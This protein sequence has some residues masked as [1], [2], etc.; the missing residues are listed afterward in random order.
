[1]DKYIEEARKGDFAHYQQPFFRLSEKDTEETLRNR[2]REFNE[3]GY[4]S[5]V[6]EY[7][8]NNGGL[9][10]TTYFDADWWERLQYVV[11]ICR[12]LGMTFWMQDA[13]PFPT[14]SANGWFEQEE[15]KHKS[16]KFIKE[17]HLD[18]VGPVS[19]TYIAINDVARSIRGNLKEALQH[20]GSMPEQVL[21]VVAARR[22]S[23]GAGY[24]SSSLIDL[25][26]K[27]KDGILRADFP[28]G[29]WRVFVIVQSYS[30][31]RMHFMNLLDA[32]SV[33][34]QIDAV[35]QPHY[36]F[37]KDEVGKTWRG[38][39]YDEPE[40]GNLGGYVFDNLP[41]K[42]HNAI[43]L[44]LPWCDE[45]PSV[46]E[47][48]IG[49]QHTQYLPML[50]YPF[51]QK[52]SIVRHAYMDAV[53]Q[54]I[55]RNYNGQ[56]Y[57]WCEERGITYIGHALED[58]NSHTRL[59]CGPGHFFRMQEGQHI[60]G[61]DLVGGQIW[62]GMDFKGMSWYGS[63]D[64]DG[65]FYHYGL[66][67]LASSA[68]HI[69]PKKQGKSLCENIGLYGAIAGTK[70]RKFIVDHLLVNGINHFI[71]AEDGLDLNVKYSN[72]LN[73]YVDRMC[74]IVQG[75]TH[76]AP[77]AVLYHAD[78]EW[79]G[80]FQ[81]FHEPGKVLATNQIDYDVIPKDVFVDRAY[82]GTAIERNQ[83]LINNE[84]YRAL[85]IPYAER[86]AKDV[87]AFIIE[88]IAEEF[89]VLFVN[90]YPEGY[91]ESE[92]PLPEKLFDCKV[93]PLD[94][95]ASYLREIGIYDISLS[96]PQHYLRYMH[97]ERD[98]VDLYM[99]HNE[100][101][102]NG[103]ETVVSIPN[104]K[105][106]VRYDVMDNRF[107]KADAAIFTDHSEIHLQLRQFEAQIYIFSNEPVEA[108]LALAA[109]KEPVEAPW[110]LSFLSLDSSPAPASI[111]LTALID[112]AQVEQYA[113][114]YGNMIYEG[115]IHINNR[116]PAFLSLGALYECVEV[117][118][119][120]KHVG[121]AI[122]EPYIFYIE[123]YLIEGSN[124]LKVIVTNNKVRS[125][126]HM[127][128]KDPMWGTL[129]A[130][131][132][133]SFEAFGLIGPVELIYLQGEKGEG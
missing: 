31:G 51:D 39:F 103:I 4:Y 96:N 54:L 81:Y 128:G 115:T 41:G 43:H 37:L 105:H 47:G 107:Y 17:K 52:T 34:V 126:D 90:G 9:S 72:K 29:I 66:A 116:I 111:Q 100:E 58:E 18:V 93:I 30:G 64:G 69:D 117:Y 94:S 109:S 102:M 67:K 60:A 12:E 24:D 70:I 123:D 44:P 33:R 14:G 83:L 10:K 75:G 106:V 121:V 23:D 36:E 22:L 125:L 84:K 104:T 26:D 73:Q 8:K 91:C 95:I 32:E 127:N 92:E 78:A 49:E 110:K 132:Y 16:K 79:S 97:I 120:D 98:G 118:V 124:I 130:G 13:A 53:T 35:H 86:I 2:I 61:V 48:L 28:T 82:Y 62:P 42:D 55:A 108:E 20:I 129:S 25:T 46:L 113:N 88:A 87:V 15:H 71:P 11:N 133:H 114:F 1:M 56:V 5:F 40:I 50:W 99:F 57:K 65:E 122:A 3:H 59:G 131:T 45:L 19:N 80:E 77:V 85:I 38:F 63:L 119:N 6:I 21:H 68:A 74:H 101:P 76:I 7:T 112:L 89:P 27:V